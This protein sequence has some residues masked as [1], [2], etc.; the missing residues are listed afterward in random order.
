[1]LIAI[2]HTRFRASDSN[3]G[4]RHHEQTRDGG[5]AQSEQYIASWAGLLLHL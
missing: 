5:K 2:C 4:L 3:L 1:V